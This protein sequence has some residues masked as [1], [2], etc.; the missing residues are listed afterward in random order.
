MKTGAL[1]LEYLE[2]RKKK[3]SLR[4]R[5]RRRGDE[6]IR[7]IDTYLQDGPPR[8]IL[9]VGT[10]E[11]AMLS[12]LRQKYDARAVGLEYVGELLLRGED[13]ALHRLQGDAQRLPVADG[14]VDVVLA[15]AVIEHV[16]EPSRV[17]A[18][19]FRVL[20]SGGL[21][22]VTAPD[23]FWE[24]LATSVGHLR[25]DQH[26][27]VPNLALLR[28]WT[29]G[30]GFNVLE[31]EKFMLSPVGMPA[32]LEVERVVRRLGLRFLMANQ[33]VVGRKP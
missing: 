5:L 25:D 30:A 4:Y 14:V 19:A 22:V 18:E 29:H 3:P 6:V 31:A 11:G 26:N 24:H 27:I 28:S 10:A 12:R 32:E 33:I 2:G 13:P 23:P 8:T 7:A 17:T 15:C 9:D 1:D 20:R 21:F 16:P